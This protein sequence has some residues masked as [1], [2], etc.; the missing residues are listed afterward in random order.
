MYKRHFKIC[1]VMLHGKQTSSHVVVV[2][3]EEKCI[4]WF[5]H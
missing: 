2:N 4:K 5:M 3:H 1:C